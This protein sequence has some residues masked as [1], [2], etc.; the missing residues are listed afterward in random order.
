[1]KKVISIVA[2]ALIFATGIN[3]KAQ[4]YKFGH[5][6]SQKLMSEMPESQDAQKKL[7]AEQ[8]SIRDQL[9]T[10]QVEL[11]NKYNDYQNNMGLPMADPKKWSDIVREDKEK[12][13]N[14]LNQR[15]QDFQQTAGQGLQKKQQ[16][17][18]Q[19]ILEKIQ[20]AIKEVAKENKFT[21]IFEVQSLLYHSEESIDITSM[22]KTK[23][24]TK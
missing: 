24:A 10:M 6:D 14:D 5:I 15:I 22:V 9:E 23:L 18:L 3:L 21:Y 19:P 13:M 8:K 4:T 12:E 7:E 2:L 1:M 16:E 17:L 20:N 11:N